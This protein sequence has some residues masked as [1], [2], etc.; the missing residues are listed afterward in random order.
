ME[1]IYNEQGQVGV[2]VSY[3]YGTGWST[4]N[5][6]NPLDKRYN[7]LILNKE[8]DKAEALALEEGVQY[9]SGLTDCVIVW[10]DEGEMFQVTEYNG[11]EGISTMD[12]FSYA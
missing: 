2:A 5:D 7:E 12:C 3:G 9:C 6:V 8:W 4:W 10:I 1:K 11:F